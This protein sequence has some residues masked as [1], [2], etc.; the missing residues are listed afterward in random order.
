MKIMGTIFT[1]EKVIDIT[2]VNLKAKAISFRNKDEYEKILEL[3]EKEQEILINLYKR[4]MGDNTLF[5]GEC[6]ATAMQ[7]EG[8]AITFNMY[9]AKFYNY[10]TTGM[11]LGN[12]KELYLLCETQEEKDA[13]YKVY[14]NYLALNQNNIRRLHNT[15]K[16]N[17]NIEKARVMFSL[18]GLSR[19]T[20]TVAVVYDD[21]SVLLVR[22]GNDTPVCPNQISATMGGFMTPEDL[23]GENPFKKCLIRETEE[24]LGIKVEDKDVNLEFML[25][26]NENYQPVV[27]ATVKSD[28]EKLMKETNPD[29]FKV[30]N[31]KYIHLK[32]SEIPQLLES[33]EKIVT[34]CSELLKTLMKGE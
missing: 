22:R 32:R 11:V 3:S 12:Y 33:D 5:N 23:N 18:N 19:V 26:D 28:I 21:T 15:S 9:K 24:E 2:T 7:L 16:N 4:R 8:D 27:C 34:T 1:Q 10:L 29:K 14:T 13:I 31:S 30:E 17:D 20:G 25:I 6:V